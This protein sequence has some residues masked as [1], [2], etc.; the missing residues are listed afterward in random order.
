MMERKLNAPKT[1][2]GALHHHGHL[3]AAGGLDVPFKQG[4]QEFQ[5]QFQ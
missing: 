1:R 2:L 3:R 5:S 4:F